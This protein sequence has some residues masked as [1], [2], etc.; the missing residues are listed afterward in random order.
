MTDPY[1]RPK[2]RPEKTDPK[3]PTRKNRPEKTVPKDRPSG[4]RPI[5][6]VLPA[7]RA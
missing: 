5:H 4:R 2:D 6:H 7:V 3:K 1:D